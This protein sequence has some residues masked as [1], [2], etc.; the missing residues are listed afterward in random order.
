V[1]CHGGY[2]RGA[3]SRA[4]SAIAI[5][6]AGP[7]SL[8]DGMLEGDVI[9]CCMHMGSFHVKAWTQRVSASVVRKVKPGVL[10]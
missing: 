7:A 5:K 3:I 8:A 1:I 4:F 6:T 2:A 10:R 9:E